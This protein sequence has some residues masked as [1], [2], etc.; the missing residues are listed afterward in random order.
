MPDTPFQQERKCFRKKGWWNSKKEAHKRAREIFKKSGT[1]MY[2]Y[3]CSVCHKVHLTKQSN[4]KGK[5]VI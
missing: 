4:V 1:R 2:P 5:S 3:R